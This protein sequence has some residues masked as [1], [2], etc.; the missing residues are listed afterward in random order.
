[1]WLRK[2][3]ENPHRFSPFK[4]KKKKETTRYDHVKL[5]LSRFIVKYLFFLVKISYFD[6]YE[7]GL[8]KGLKF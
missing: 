2:Y 4:K 7:R 3:R 8:L 6:E 5:V 1:M